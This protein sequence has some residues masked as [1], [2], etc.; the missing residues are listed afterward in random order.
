MFGAAHVAARLLFL[1]LRR[2]ELKELLEEEPPLRDNLREIPR[3]FEVSGLE[4]PTAFSNAAVADRDESGDDR[5][6]RCLASMDRAMDES[7]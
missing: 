7:R 2:P 1:R 3:D 4:P 5:S 6:A